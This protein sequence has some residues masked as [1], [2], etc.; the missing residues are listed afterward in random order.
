M[1]FKALHSLLEIAHAVVEHA[2]LVAGLSV[3]RFLG[4][5]GFGKVDEG[6]EGF[7]GAREVV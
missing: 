6:L 4:G 1:S 3:G 5:I 7:G 2:Q